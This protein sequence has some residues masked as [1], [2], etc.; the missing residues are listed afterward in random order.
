MKA[1]QPLIPTFDAALATAVADYQ[2]SD[3]ETDEDRVTGSS[4]RKRAFRQA[5]AGSKLAS[6]S[7]VRD[8][9]V[10]RWVYEP[11]PAS[12]GRRRG[13]RA[14]SLVDPVNVIPGFQ[15]REIP[16]N[17]VRKK[18]SEL[19]DKLTPNRGL[20]AW[21]NGKPQAYDAKKMAGPLLLL[22]HGTFSKGDMYLEEFGSTPE[23]KTF[24]ANAAKNYSAILTFD[25]PTLTVA[26][27]LNALDL[28][29]ELGVPKGPI[30]VVCH[31][32]GGMV[33]SWW[34]YFYQPKVRNVVFVASPL[35]GTSLA[36]PARIKSALD[37]LGNLARG[38]GTVAN[39]AATVVPM[40][41]VAGGLMKILGGVISF[42][43]RS[44]LLD[45]GVGLVP[46][47]VAQSRDAS[48]FEL[49]RLYS[50]DWASK[51]RIHAVQSNYEPPE[52]V[53]PWW[54]FW[55]RFRQIPGQLANFG[56]DKVFAG[57]NDLVV[58]FASMTQM[59]VFTIPID[60][61]LDLTAER[62]VHHCAYFRQKKTVEFLT[63]VLELK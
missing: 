8:D 50:S 38:V 10:L 28:Q 32:R 48:N 11:P 16:P 15:F 55:S 33:A 52:N 44:S 22:I 29:R 23:G 1:S 7:L 27:W 51:L 26:P 6:V 19:D 25:H 36:A 14:L 30:D 56:A 18:L 54:K 43:A 63:G 24:L 60:N 42:T 34:F 57:P 31:S 45:A 41:A 59:G 3:I 46:G 62:S 17:E 20:R 9:E 35:E 47:L 21:V 40:L 39:T 12:I 49:E 61:R 5:R 58:D 2:L 37:L 4:V 53:D 13:R